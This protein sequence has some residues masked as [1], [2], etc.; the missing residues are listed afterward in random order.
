VR[1]DDAHAHEERLVLQLAN[2]VAP[3]FQ[4]LNSL[5]SLNYANLV[6]GW[7]F[8]EYTTDNWENEYFNSPTNASGFFESAQD[9][10]VLINQIDMLFTNGS[11]SEETRDIIREAIG[12]IP[13]TLSGAR[14]KINLVLY[15]TLVSPDYLI[16]K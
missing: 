3:E 8:W 9:D 11:M 16:K 12:W 7:T 6:Y 14:E 1:G 2:L 10:E 13:P 15:L 5:T 4:I